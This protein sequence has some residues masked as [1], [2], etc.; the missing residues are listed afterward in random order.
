MNN[1][2]RLSAKGDMPTSRFHRLLYLP[3]YQRTVVN[4]PSL[5]RGGGRIDEQGRPADPDVAFQR[6]DMLDD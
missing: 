5:W 4:I 3:L 1:A 2:P 6:G